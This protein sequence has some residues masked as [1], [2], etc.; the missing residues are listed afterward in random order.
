MIQDLIGA[1]DCLHRPDMGKINLRYK[2]GKL[3]Y[4]ALS[5]LEAQENPRSFK[6]KGDHCLVFGWH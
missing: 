6:I 5:L 4:L 1:P 2:L 3:Q